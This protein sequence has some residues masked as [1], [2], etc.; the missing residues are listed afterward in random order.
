MN[1]S[2]GA[3]PSHDKILAIGKRI[4]RIQYSGQI[5]RSEVL[6]VWIILYL[7][8]RIASKKEMVR[9][10]RAARLT[11]G[12]LAPGIFPLSLLHP[13]RGTRHPPSKRNL[14]SLTLSIAAQAEGSGRQG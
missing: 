9:K 3:C 5:S 1:L 10:L 8:L 6:H 7:M 4:F 11:D 14:L 13:P 2:K 12:R